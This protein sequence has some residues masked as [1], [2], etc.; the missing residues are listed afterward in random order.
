MRWQLEA[1]L[2]IDRAVRRRAATE[3]I[4]FA[5]GL[6]LRHPELA[7]VHYLNA[8]MLDCARAPAGADEVVA[9]AE[10][11]LSD[12]PDRHVVFDDAAAGERIAAELAPAG[13]ERRRT[14]FMVITGSGGGVRP[15]PRGRR[16]SEAELRGLQLAGIREDLS[17]VDARSGLPERLVATQAALRAGTCARAFGADDEGR[18]AS[19]GTLFLDQDLHGRRVAMLDEVGTLRAH[20]QRG[21]ARAVITAAIA[22][23]HVWGAELTVVP[24]DSDDWPQ[25]IYARLGFAPA[26]RQVA[27][28]LRS[29]PASGSGSGAL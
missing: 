12:R 3:S 17:D 26:G 11:W 16:I 20:R 2:A 21:L 15:D 5:E 9:L 18:L 24:A 22:E 28:T 25:L 10:Q 29:R 1:G 27:L 14:T 6:V 23:A 7:D 13:W 19:T 8:L 4:P